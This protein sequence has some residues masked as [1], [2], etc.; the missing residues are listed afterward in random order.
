MPFVHQL[1]LGRWVSAR[2]YVSRQP[3]H[4]GALPI[5][6]YV[7]MDYHSCGFLA[8][9]AVVRHFHPGTSA[10]E[11]LRVLRP[12]TASG[13]DHKQL[14][15]GI[16][17]LGVEAV[18]RERLGPERLRGLIL[19]GYPVIVTVWPDDYLC[20]HWTVV[21]GVVGGRVLLTN[22]GCGSLPWSEFAGVWYPRGCGLVC[23][24]P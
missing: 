13:C 10:D 19:S 8:A 11:V 21:R 14:V 20:D 12:S 9:L 3:H 4:R 18:Y 1:R 22:Y 17:R 23:G 15:R 2:F 24:G 6:R 7:Q 16:R 5:P